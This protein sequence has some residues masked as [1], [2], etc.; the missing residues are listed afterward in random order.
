[1]E[2]IQE[3]A[4]L[5]QQL[6]ERRAALDPALAAKWDECIARHVL[7]SDFFA[8]ADCVFL[9]V[10]VGGEVDTRIIMNAAFEKGKAVAVP[11]C[12]AKGEMGFFSICGSGDLAS[13]AYGIPEPLAVCQ[14]V[15][16]T[17]RS[18]CLVP[19]LAFDRRGGR[20]G[21]GGGYY[22]RFLAAFP[23]TAAGLVRTAFLADCL[24]A[25]PFDQRVNYL[26]TQDG[27]LKT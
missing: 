12:G 20:I 16:P 15:S 13:G 25:G 24:P 6:K 14:K 21:Y 5:R 10:S 1:M 8:Q 17:A 3:K 4:L 2:L 11:R 23:G 9:Y 22:D 26:V 18:L 7:G 27:W 19:A